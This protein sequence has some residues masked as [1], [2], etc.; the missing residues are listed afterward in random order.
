MNRKAHGS[1]TDFMVDP[2]VASMLAFQRG[3]YDAFQ[4]LVERHTEALVSYFFF[5]SRDRQL[6]EDCSQD[7]W[8]KVFKSRD[9][10][11][12]RARF[13]T[14]L[15]RV[16]RNHWIDRFRTRAR[17]PRETPLEGDGQDAES[18]AGP[19]TGCPQA[20]TIRTHGCGALTL[21]E[22]PREPSSAS[23]RRCVRST[24]WQRSR[25]SRTPRWPTCSAYPW[26]P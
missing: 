20:V 14:F 22:P 12:P 21:P 24:S 2:D 11:Q 23:L 9:D 16:A 18:G 10:Y 25:N 15:F 3:D 8:L 26:G 4:G 17:R 6:A 19:W 1:L 7:V 13:R 5:Q